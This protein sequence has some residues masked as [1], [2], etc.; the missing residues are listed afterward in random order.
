MIKY[1]NERVK[2]L[3]AWDIALIKWSVV[4]A[5]IIL[6]KLLPKLLSINYV[7]LVILMIACMARPIYKIWIKK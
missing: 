2:A 5:T 6:V 3:T 4:F 1:L 7:V